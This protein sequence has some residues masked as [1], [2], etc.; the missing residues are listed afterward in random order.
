M[1]RIVAVLA[2][3]L[4]AVSFA[5]L[6]GFLRP[7]E[8][9]AAGF[10]LFEQSGRGLG[11]A[12]AGE[13]AVAMD[14]TTLYYNP[15]GMVLLPGTQFSSSGFVIYTRQNFENRGTRFADG[16]IDGGEIPGNSGGNG[17]GIALVPTFFLTHQFH[18]RVS[19]GIGLSTPFGLETDWPR[20]W[21]G[22]YH[23]RLSRLLTINVN[24]SLAVRLTDWLSIGAGANAQWAHARL[25]NNLDMGSICQILGPQQ[26]TPIPPEVCT[27]FLGLEPGKV[28]GYVKLKGSDWSAGYNIGLLFLPWKGTRIGLT[29]RSRIGHTLTGDARFSVP[30]KAEILRT[31]SGAL[32]KTDASASVTLPDRAS[33]SL[34][35]EVTED[36]QFLADVTWTH[37]S[38]FDQLVF[39]FENP[40]QPQVVE[41]ENWNDSLRYSLGLVYVLNEMWSF[42]TGFAYDNSPVPSRVRLT[43]RIPD[44][45]RYWLAVGLG[46]RPTSRIRI[47]LSY[48]HIFSPQVSTRNPDPITHARLIGNFDSNG[49][50]FAFQLTYDI[51]WTFSDPFGTATGG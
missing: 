31:A 44:S 26:P 34:Y 11:S 9:Q 37:W 23:A 49:D 25:N 17:G 1:A 33:I 6:A 38:L 4:V 7:A 15:A 51:D 12:F 40:R 32:R 21:V 47:D 45:D 27:Q 35:Q 24:P 28:N 3:S 42:R 29:Y 14:P 13:G 20:N 50:L 19:A 18:E 16:I 2:R 43:P 8:L 36:L 10:L 39:K 30:P 46:I 41:P 5:A 22:R 48:A